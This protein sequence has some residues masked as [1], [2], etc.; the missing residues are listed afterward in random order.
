MRNDEPISF[1]ISSTRHHNKLV[2]RK[3]ITRAV[4]A[5]QLEALKKTGE[6][7][8]KERERAERN[9]LARWDN[10]NRKKKKKKC[11]R[12]KKKTI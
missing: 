1:L 6:V 7:W 5:A 9:A 11:M 4:E 8:R 12:R 2:G 3:R 10:N